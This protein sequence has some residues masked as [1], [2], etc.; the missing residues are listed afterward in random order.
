M[1]VVVH[2]EVI[3][4]DDLGDRSYVVHDGR[5]A[6]VVD[7]NAYRPGRKGAGRPRCAVCD[8]GGN[9][10]PHDY[11]TGG[12]EL[13]RRAGC[14][15]VVSADDPVSFDRRAVRDGDALAMGR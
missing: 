13:S 8:G 11:V 5:S 14:P 3:A 10:Y 2:V 1:V 4:T 6:V 12:F 15:Y 7:P 9:P